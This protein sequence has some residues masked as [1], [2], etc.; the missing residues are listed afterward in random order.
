MTDPQADQ[1]TPRIVRLS[2]INR[3]PFTITD[4]FDGIPVTFPTDQAVDVSPEIAMHLFGYPGELEDRA[5]HMARRFGWSGKEYLA[6]EGQGDSEP[7]YVTMSR[8]IEIAP[9][10][11]NLVRVDPNAPIKLDT[12]DEAADRA[13]PGIEADTGTRVGTRKKSQSKAQRRPRADRHKPGA[14]MKLGAR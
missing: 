7:K 3:N 5:V 13:T 8:L 12:G 1:A 10:Y 4:M 9:V 6:P 2:V 11:Y 14:A